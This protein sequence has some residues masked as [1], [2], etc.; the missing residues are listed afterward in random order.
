MTQIDKVVV[1]DGLSEDDTD[2]WRETT[3]IVPRGDPHR[4]VGELKEGSENLLVRYAVQPVRRAGPPR[5]EQESSPPA[6]GGPV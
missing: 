4:V 5:P 6:E 1:S 3:R 2:P